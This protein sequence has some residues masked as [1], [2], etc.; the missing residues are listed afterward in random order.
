MNTS[1]ILAQYLSVKAQISYN[2]ME[3]SKWA[4]LHENMASKLAKQTKAEERW[5]KA[6]DSIIENNGEKN[7]KIGNDIYCEK[8]V[9]YGDTKIESKAIEYAKAKAPTYDPEKL[10]EYAE[11]DINYD[12]M[13]TTYETLLSQLEAQGETLKTSLGNATKDTGM[14]E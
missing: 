13:Q 12:L 4:G 8:D 14:L 6:S 1:A 3:S 5:N 9:V 7:I 11:L 10:E 2:Q